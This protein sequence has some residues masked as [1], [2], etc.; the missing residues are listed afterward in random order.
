MRAFLI[1]ASIYASLATAE[2]EC[3]D[4]DLILHNG[5]IYTGNSDDSFV[6]SI[7]SKG[8]TISY[9]GE[10]LS[11]TELSCSDAKIID[12]SGRYV[13][14]GFIDAHGHLK[15]IGYRELTLILQGISS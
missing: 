13:F 11:D 7:T 14:P 12:L 6:G 3:I 5:N 4:A 10:L 1:I 2:I 8:S 15:G 9:V